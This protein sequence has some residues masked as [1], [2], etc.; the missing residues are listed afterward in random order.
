MSERKI[1]PSRATGEGGFLSEEIKT[2][3]G[4]FL[5]D[6]I[7]EARKSSKMLLKHMKNHTFQ[8]H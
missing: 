6:E 3:E 1:T 4:G 7:R 2:F 5:K 8:I